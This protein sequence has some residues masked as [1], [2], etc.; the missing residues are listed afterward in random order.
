[1]IFIGLQRK[2]DICCTHNFIYVNLQEIVQSQ[3]LLDTESFY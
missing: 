1:M 2:K 3:K